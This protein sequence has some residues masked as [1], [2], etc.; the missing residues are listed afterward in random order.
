LPAFAFVAISGPLVPKVRASPVAG[1]FLDGV[2]VASLALMA[3][4]SFRLSVAA[5]TS[6][7]TAAIAA[8]SFVLLVRYRLN[9]ASLI[10]G[11]AALGFLLLGR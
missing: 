8:A 5:V 11:G 10:A 4:V 7:V 1:A 6:V 3:V 9:S 2:N